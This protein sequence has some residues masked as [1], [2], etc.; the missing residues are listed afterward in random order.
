MLI[1]FIR[2]FIH[3]GLH[4][5]FPLAIAYQLSKSKK[6]MWRYYFLQIST[7]IIDFDHFLA[8]PVFDSSRC[9]IG[10]HPLHSEVAILV[11]AVLLIP[12]KTRI[13]GI[14]LVTHIFTD[15]IDCLFII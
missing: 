8:S 13:T 11:Y 14:G 5:A 9:S 7:M 1:Q 3:Y 10:F 4:F 12:R 6:Q 15:A 2:P